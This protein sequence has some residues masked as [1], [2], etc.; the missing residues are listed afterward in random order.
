M[1]F[2]N[3]GFGRGANFTNVRFESRTDFAGVHSTSKAVPIYEGVVFTRKYYGDDESFWRFIKQ[4]MQEAGYYK[5]AGES[6]Y[7]ER[8]ANF[9]FRFRGAN[10]D[11]LTRGQK[12]LQLLKGVRLMPELILGRLLFGYGE[13]PV[14]VII[15]AMVVIL[16]CG[17]FYSSDMASL[18]S[19]AD[20]TAAD[21]TLFE[22]VYFSTITFAT[23]GLGDIYPAHSDSITRLVT[24]AE[25][26]SGACLM[27]LFVVCLAKRYSRG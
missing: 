22:G 6:F 20:G 15:S 10:Y 11:K 23:L 21:L 25:A 1:L 19:R 4:S 3:T 12:A 16:L 7:Q 26:L 18:I 27:S 17:L 14:R 24:M 13:R 8:C 2:T 9:W 5:Q